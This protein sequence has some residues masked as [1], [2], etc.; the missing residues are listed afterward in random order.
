MVAVISRKAFYVEEKWLATG[1]E[2]RKAHFLD[3]PY[4]FPLP[5]G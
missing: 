1:Y 5:T 3:N 4:M 2:L